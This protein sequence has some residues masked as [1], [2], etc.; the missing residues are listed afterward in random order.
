M[1]QAS[2]RA[3][4]A[5]SIS[6]ALHAN[7]VP[8]IRELA[9][10]NQGDQALTDLRLSLT[11]EPGFISGKAWSVSSIAA[12]ATYHIPTLD[13]ELDAGLL[14]RLEEAT[15]AR[16]K[17]SLTRGDEELARLDSELRLLARNQWSGIGHVPELICA[18]RRGSAGRPARWP[19]PTPRPWAPA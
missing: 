16:I 6:L 4:I 11:A 12:G 1:G 5:P 3:A 13:F 9:V 17:L 15:P 14:S 18:F 19:P 7:S 10:E 8:S 2:I